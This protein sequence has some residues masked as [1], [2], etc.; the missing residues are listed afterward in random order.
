M[1][2]KERYGEILEEQWR[3]AAYRD[4]L[5]YAQYVNPNY[6][7]NWHHREIGDLLMRMEA[8][9]ED[10]GMVVLPPRH[11]KSLLCSVIF[12]AWYFGRNPSNEVIAWSYGGDLAHGFGARLRNLMSGERHRAVFGEDGSLS[13]DT[14]ARDRFMTN[15]GGVYRSAGSQGGITGFGAHLFIIDDPVK[16]FEEANSAIVQKKTWDTYVNDIYPR[17]MKGSA[18]LEIQTRW[19]ET[20]LAGRLLDAQKSGGD[21]WTV[22]YYPASRHRETGVPINPEDPDAVALWE[23]DFPIKDLIRKFRVMSMEDPR[24]WNT[25]FQGNPM[26]ETGD[27]F[28]SGWL[29]TYGVMPDVSTLRIY[30][31]SDYAV[32][33]QGGDYTVHLV[34]GVDRDHNIYILDMWRKQTSSD[35]WIEA[36]LD[37]A[38]R[39]KPIIWAEE[40]GQIRRG[41]GPLI[42][43]MM[44]ERRI[45]FARR[46]FSSSADKP[47]RARSIAGRMAAGKVYFPSMAPW[48]GDMKDELLKFDKGKHDDIVDTLSLV[49]RL[50]DIIAA[51]KSAEDLPRPASG[52]MIQAHPGMMLPDGMTPVTMGDIVEETRR[53]RRE[54]AY[55]LGLE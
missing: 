10:R 8:G 42:S 37:L 41:V 18:M 46:D 35:K 28:E 52:L 29:R 17:L 14:R 31:A 27:Y 47:T 36:L 20:D 7:V 32:T 54:N 22:L 45:W 30:G 5:A 19:N 11:G 53:W 40:G 34:F 6:R 43:R 16:G 33:H 21:K 2:D 13:M 1:N 15:A 49:G 39:W 3:R 38:H 55:E 51:G 44:Q 4:V 24:A 23:E 25:E 50:L 48:W 9:L 26:P 12:P